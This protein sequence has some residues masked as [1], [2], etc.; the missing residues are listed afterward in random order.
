MS[1]RLLTADLGRMVSGAIKSLALLICQAKTYFFIQLLIPANSTVTVPVRCKGGVLPHKKPRWIPPAKSKMFTL[2]RIDHT[3]QEEIEQM[4]V[5]KYNYRA[6]FNAVTQY[7]YE[8]STSPQSKDA[9]LS[10]IK[11]REYMF[12]NVEL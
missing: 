2:K 6:H 9:M 11:C 1:M 5:L 3:P 7:L 4:N 8:V 12:Y 10:V